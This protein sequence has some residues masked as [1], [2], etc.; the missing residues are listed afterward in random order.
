[1]FSQLHA[2]DATRVFSN[3]RLPERRH[4]CVA[5]EL[6]IRPHDCGKEFGIH[7][8]FMNI[9]KKARIFVYR[10][11]VPESCFKHLN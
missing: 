3:P 6:H 10:V 5:G 2:Y 7:V 8:L 9:A 11:A 1:M 4:G